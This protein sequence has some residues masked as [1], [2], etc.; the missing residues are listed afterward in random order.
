M[1]IPIDYPTLRVIWWLLL[2]ILLIGF[3]VMD[4]FDLGIGILLHRVARTNEERR[5]VLNTVGPV[6]EGNQIWFIL[7]GGAIFA[8]W[9]EIYAV[10]FSGFYFAMLLILLALILRPVGFKYR[11]KIQNTNWR[12]FWDICLFISGFVPALVFGVAVGNVLQGVTFHYD[13]TLRSFFTGTFWGL[14]NPFALLCGLISVCML[15][16]HG[17]SFLVI[18]TEGVIQERAIN[19]VRLFGIA[20]IILFAVAGFWLATRIPGYVVTSNILFDA[21]ANP[22][23]KKVATQLGA[24]LANYSKY[25]L[26]LAAPACG[27]GGAIL[28]IWLAGLRRGKLAWLMSA[29]SVTGIITTVGV[30]MFP[31]I[32]PSSTQP[33]MSLLVW[34]ASASQL[35]LFLMLIATVIF[36]PL[37]IAYTSWVYYVLR[38]KVTRDYFNQ[39]QNN[40][41]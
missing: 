11:S 20:T 21:P 41:Y 32:L 24:W 25:P 8:A 9:P 2:G 33:D 12:S 18:K 14:L 31:F 29:T 35:T 13:D 39:N 22:L 15:A 27:F 34:D 17:A 23:H 36:I 10:S 3:A 30:S 37:I 26:T 19:Y 16:M 6:W 40:L 5:I 28:A 38:G 7:G 4:G 1:T